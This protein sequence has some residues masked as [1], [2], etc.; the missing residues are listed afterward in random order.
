MIATKPNIR[1][2]PREGESWEYEFSPN[3]PRPKGSRTAIPSVRDEMA[4]MG[5]PSQ[6]S[7][8]VAPMVVLFLAAAGCFAFFAH[9]G[10][11]VGEISAVALLPCALHGLWRGGFRKTVMLAATLGLFYLLSIKPDFAAPLVTAVTGSTGGVANAVASGI[12]AM[13]TWIAVF[14][15]ARTINR[16]VIETRRFLSFTNRFAGALIGGAEG[17]LMV[18]TVCWCASS[19]KPFAENLVHAD[20]AVAGSAQTR[21]GKYMMQIAS[22][23]DVGLLGQMTRATNPIHQVPALRNAVDQLNTTGHLDF[24]SVDPA[25]IKEVQD[26]LRQSGAADAA[27][28]SEL[29]KKLNEKAAAQDAANRPVPAPTGR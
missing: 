6:S 1:N 10:H 13:I 29:V 27:G 25:T 19:L 26:F 12:I 21:I 4:V 17:A 3:A 23:A 2:R 22:E 18:L 8:L 15:I 7:T 16:R 28:M 9:R 20:D 24:D 11:L 5:R 14:F